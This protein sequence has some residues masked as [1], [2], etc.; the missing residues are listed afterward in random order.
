MGPEK[1]QEIWAIIQAVGGVYS[2]ALATWIVLHPPGFPS[3]PPNQVAGPMSP[4]LVWWQLVLVIGLAVC[5][6][7]LAIGAF[8]T[9]V[10]LLRDRKNRKREKL[11]IH[12]AVYG[13][14]PE[15]DKDVTSV[16]QKHN[17]DA[18]AFDVENN[19]FGIDPAPMK[20]KRLEV[21]YSYG[22]RSVKKISRPEGT[23]LVI[24]ED[25][26]AQLE[27]RRLTGEV[28]GLAQRLSAATAAA[29]ATEPKLPLQ[30]P[31]VVPVR[32]GTRSSD[33]RAGIFIENHG[34]PAFDV[35]LPESV[36]IG[37]S[38][39]LFITEFP[40]LKRED[41]AVLCEAHIQQ[42]L[43]SGLLGSGLFEEMRKLHVP[44]VEFSIHYKDADNKRY[45]TDCKI[46]RDVMKQGGLAVRFLGQRL[47]DAPT[48]LTVPAPSDPRIRVEIESVPTN[49][50]PWRETR[51]ILHNEGGSTAYGI[52][53][54]DIDLSSPKP[55]NATMSF[56][57]QETMPIDARQTV[58]ATVDTQVT[59]F[60]NDA[61]A[62]LNWLVE[63]SPINEVIRPIDITYRDYAGNRFE[64]HT[65]L[66]YVPIPP[67]TQAEIAADFQ[68]VVDQYTRRNPAEVSVQRPAKQ[69]R[70]PFTVRNHRFFRVV[71]H[72]AA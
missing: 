15:N 27:V 2:S 38:Q 20:P 36:A 49:K 40:N 46:E 35:S 5:A 55:K 59:L 34:D 54:A 7:A 68:L 24:P 60:E 28:E 42:S 18:L 71:K 25:Q 61:V 45:A 43:G 39:L 21:E 8:G 23:R 66:Q 50:A 33:N 17:R 32:Y 16:L 56:R 72:E 10:S 31:R 12:S 9:F 62:F 47:A 41:G 53:V 6:L 69:V 52:E 70:N 22:N 58:T 30:R 29:E 65:E 3:A 48:S 44:E 57:V 19:S 37:Q 67:E 4:H 1:R 63:D 14:G 13:S 51:I 26:Y 11:E 64:T